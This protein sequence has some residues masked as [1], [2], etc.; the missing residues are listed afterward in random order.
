MGRT[1]LYF[2]TD[3]HGSTRCFRKFLNAA[4]SYGADVLVLGGDITGK[5]IIPI[6]EKDGR[7]ACHSPGAELVLDTPAEVEEFQKREA[8]SGSYAQ[9]VTPSEYEELRADPGKVESLFVKL[10]VE[11][12]REW[13]A[14]AEER[15]AKTSVRCFISPGNDD[16]FEIDPVLGSSP[17][18]VDPEERV[19]SIDGEHEMITL[20]Y[21]NRT[22][23]KSPRE[24]DED[25][26]AGMI[27]AMAD[28]VSDMRTAIFN[29]HVPPIDTTLDQAPRL[30]SDLKA[31]V[32]AGSVEMA[33]A[34]SSA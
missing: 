28:R 24:V 16:A 14:L 30:D 21:T 7:F 26:L 18:V 12:V 2:V 19:V 20:G 17:Y 33:S 31:V 9:V 6:V 4:K 27:S 10:M 23:W 13:L 22:P 15:L 1:R 8:E 5:V 34:G 32:K 29:V 3:V 11:R 25:S